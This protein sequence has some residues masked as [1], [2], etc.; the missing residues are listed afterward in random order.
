MGRAV[1]LNTAS[2]ASTTG[3]TFADNLVANSGDTLAVANFPSGGARILEAWAIDSAHVAELQII[4][5]RPDSS[6]DQQHGIRFMIP[7][8][9]LGG[10]GTN[11]A[12]N[13]LPGYGQIPLSPSDTPLVQVTS[14]AT[15]AVVYSFVTEYDN[16]PGV[17]GNFA[18]W[19]QVQALRKSTFGFRSNAQAS[20]TKGAYG[21]ARAIN[22]DDDR[23]H[24][25]S[26]YA[27][28]GVSVQTQVTT[29]SMIGPDWGGQRIGLPAG[30]LY[31]NSPTYFVEQAVKWGKPMIPCFQANNKNNTF[32]QVVDAAAS[33][34]PNIDVFCYELTNAPF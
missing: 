2:V 3:G 8:V 34:T 11:A 6:H 26:W 33:T 12:F 7:S 13:L 9:A 16:L 24:A 30:S 15:D 1:V 31:L 32:I 10:A 5:T 19:D 14:T 20:G 25:G 27:I 23:F 4:Y 29:V 22:T 17:Q 28:L 21:T 18:T